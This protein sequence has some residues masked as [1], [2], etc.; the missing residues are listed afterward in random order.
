MSRWVDADLVDLVV[1]GV[2]ATLS[3]ALWVV[4]IWSTV[5]VVTRF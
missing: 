3:V 2:T 5:L 1:F 4:L